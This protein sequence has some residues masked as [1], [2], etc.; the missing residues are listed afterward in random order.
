[1]DYKLVDSPLVKPN[2]IE[3]A[4]FI[5]ERYSR[6]KHPAFDKY[7][8]SSTSPCMYD[9]EP[10]DSRPVPIPSQYNEKTKV[11]YVHGHFCSMNCAKAY[12]IDVNPNAS[13]RSLLYFAKMVAE[14]FDHQGA[15]KPA[16]PPMRLKKFPGGDLSIEEFRKAFSYWKATPLEPPF[17]SSPIAFE[18]SAPIP[19][20]QNIGCE[21]PSG[22]LFSKFLEEQ[23]GAGNMDV[24]QVESV[25]SLAL[26]SPSAS[27]S[28]SS[29][30]SSAQKRKRAK[31][32][33]ASLVAQTSAVAQPPRNSLAKF[34][35]VCQSKK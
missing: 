27:S 11:F 16:P 22:G 18:E 12:I 19:D 8:T 23:G 1:M 28:S 17:L 5:Q 33:P 29:S 26:A 3:C 32:T 10:F 2:V 15:V 34:L 21:I 24:D 9:G 31:K 6:I 13:A 14:V 4:S 20:S 30:S 25:S 7:P 35:R